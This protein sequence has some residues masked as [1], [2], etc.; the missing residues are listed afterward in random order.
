MDN[1]TLDAGTLDTR[2]IG[3]WDSE[4]GTVGRG[5]IACWD[6]GTVGQW[7][8][9]AMVD[10]TMHNRTLTWIISPR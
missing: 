3:P 4:N 1:G 5:R 6:N 2:T 8:K 9:R 10:G 7:G